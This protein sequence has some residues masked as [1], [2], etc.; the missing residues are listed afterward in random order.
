MRNLNKFG[1]VTG[2]VGVAAGLFCL[3]RPVN[4][5]N[6]WL[7]WLATGANSACFA[8]HAAMLWLFPDRDRA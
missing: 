8:Y 3:S 7:V 2:A 1:M 4:P 5:E 6:A